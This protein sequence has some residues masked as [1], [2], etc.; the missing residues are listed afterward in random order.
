VAEHSAQPAT[1]R[2]RWRDVEPGR[3]GQLSEDAP[4]PRR[5]E[6]PAAADSRSDVPAGTEGTYAA[7]APPAARE[8][9][10][11]EPEPSRETGAERRAKEA[12]PAALGR[13]GQR[14]A[15]RSAPATAVAPSDGQKA[16]KVEGLMSR[17]QAPVVPA[18]VEA[19]LAAPDRAAAERGIRAL[20]GR[21]GGIVTVPGPETLEIRVP[22]G[23]WDELTRELA[24]LGTLRIDRRPADLP[25]TVRLTLRLD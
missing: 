25:P 9:R 21:L 14:D 3:S 7:E 20:V 8:S 5:T 17:T 15:A 4:S 11:V 10:P 24:G 2:D 18:D 19:R 22:R 23:V 16:A 1:G 13:Q 6:P 12:P